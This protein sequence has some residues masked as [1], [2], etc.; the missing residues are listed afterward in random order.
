M[1]LFLGSS[2]ATHF[3]HLGLSSK[4]P[5]GQ[6]GPIWIPSEAGVRTET[7]DYAKPAMA[8]FTIDQEHWACCLGR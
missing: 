1:Q 2:G 5:G 6:Q 7:I 3:I 8:G 4:V